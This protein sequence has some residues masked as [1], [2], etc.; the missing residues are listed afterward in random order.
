MKK[1]FALLLLL[2]ALA[3]AYNPAKD[4]S[5]FNPLPISYLGFHPTYR[6]QIADI[7][8]AATATDL[9]TVCGS[10]TKTV[11][12]TYLQATADATSVGL[13]DFYVY[14]RTTAN[15]GGTST[16][17]AI[18]QM[19]SVDPAPTAAVKLYSANPSALGTGVLIA[20]DHYALPAATSTGYP[21]A[22]WIE[23]FGTRNTEALVLHGAN[24][25][26]AFGFNGDAIASGLSMYVGV[27]WVEQ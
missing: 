10:A 13:Q 1:I 14:K 27:E 12:I 21:G 18:G 20:G 24:E 23:S 16:S 8:P 5:N 9:L 4:V 3:F 26:M 17:P 2:P 15:A 7:T 25:C 11:Y 19:D 22:P 6:V